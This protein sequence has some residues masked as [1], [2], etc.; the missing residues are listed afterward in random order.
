[1]RKMNLFGFHFIISHTKKTIQVIEPNDLI[2]FVNIPRRRM[3][4]QN[5][6]PKLSTFADYNLCNLRA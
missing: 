6:W 4:Y 1:M 3:R 2:F 5:L